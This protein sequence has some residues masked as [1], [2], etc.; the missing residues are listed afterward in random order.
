MKKV[1]VAL[2]PWFYDNIL[3]WNLIFKRQ[4]PKSSKISENF[5]CRG[6]FKSLQKCLKNLVAI[7][8]R[9]VFGSYSTNSYT[10]TTIFIS[11]TIFFQS[12]FAGLLKLPLRNKCRAAN[13]EDTQIYS[14]NP[15]CNLNLLFDAIETFFG[16]KKLSEKEE[17]IR[18]L[19]KDSFLIWITSWNNIHFRKKS[20]E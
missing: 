13:S 18:D 1:N 15:Y 12:K 14:L 8:K 20:R 3:H 16:T 6:N 7:W 10:Q 5:C 17:I 2:I 9:S 4:I 11:S 19:Q